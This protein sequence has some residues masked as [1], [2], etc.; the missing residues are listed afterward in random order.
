[1]TAALQD[2]HERGLGQLGLPRVGAG[3]G[4]L[5]WDDVVAT[6]RAAAE[7]SPLD[8]VIVVRR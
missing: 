1:M 7:A 5:D 6:L 4:G 2:A 3:I 8:M